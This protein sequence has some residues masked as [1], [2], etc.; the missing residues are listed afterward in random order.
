MELL[1][2][3]GRIH[4]EDTANYDNQGCGS[5]PLGVGLSIEGAHDAWLYFLENLAHQKFIERGN[6]GT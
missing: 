3:F 6:C 2:D 4:Y 1:K 5:T